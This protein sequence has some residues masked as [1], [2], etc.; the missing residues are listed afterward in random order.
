MKNEKE[1][2]FMMEVVGIKTNGLEFDVKEIIGL[3]H[4]KINSEESEIK[5]GE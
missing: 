1:S 4:F 2:D 3:E 5:K